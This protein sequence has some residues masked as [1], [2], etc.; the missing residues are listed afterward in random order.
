MRNLKI[1]FHTI[2]PHKENFDSTTK[3][4]GIESLVDDLKN[5]V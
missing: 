1:F 2:F 5:L 3:V 4:K